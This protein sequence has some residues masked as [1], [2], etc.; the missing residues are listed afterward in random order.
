MALPDGKHPVQSRS[1]WGGVMTAIT[2][3]VYYLISV[4]YG[5]PELAQIVVASMIAVGGSL[6]IHGLRSAIGSSG[7]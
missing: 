4:K 6:G 1:I 3:L 5:D 7:R 2:P